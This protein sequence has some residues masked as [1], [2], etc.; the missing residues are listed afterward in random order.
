VAPKIVVNSF[1]F[2]LVESRKLTVVYASTWIPV[3]DSSDG[4]ARD[5]VLLLLLLLYGDAESRQVDE[6]MHMTVATRHVN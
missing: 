1:L 2:S 6:A 5:G 4:K 3:I